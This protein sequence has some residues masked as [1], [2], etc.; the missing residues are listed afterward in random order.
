M[1]FVTL[2]S[3]YFKKGTQDKGYIIQNTEDLIE[4]FNLERDTF[5]KQ[6]KRAIQNN[7]PVQKWDHLYGYL[8]IGFNTAKVKGEAS[9]LFEADNVF[10]MKESQITKMVSENKTVFVNEKGG[11]HEFKDDTHTILKSEVFD[12]KNKD[13]RISKNASFLNLEN[14]P[15]LENHTIQY[16]KNEKLDLSYLVNLYAFSK[17]ELINIFNEFSKKGRYGLYVYTT[18]TDIKQMVD[19]LEACVESELTDV[20]I[21]FNDGFNDAH[22]EIMNNFKNKLNLS[23]KTL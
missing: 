8:N 16:F 3:I 18:A 12:F 2:T 19:Y 9:P 5:H 14:D 21:E 7:I 15:I 6:F 17:E 22:K 23:F 10:R 1:N 13:L 11:Y 20:I 4:Y